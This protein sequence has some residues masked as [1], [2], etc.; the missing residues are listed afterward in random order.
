MTAREQLHEMLDHLAWANRRVWS[1]VQKSS[2][3]PSERLVAHLLAAE[4]VW[5]DRIESGT[6]AEPVWPDGLPTDGAA[7][8]E[9]SVRRI[10]GVLERETDLDRAVHYTNTRGQPF[11]TPVRHILVHL[12]L[13][14]VYHR[15][16]IAQ[17]LRSTGD[18]PEDTDFIQFVREN[19]G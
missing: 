6:S 19:N 7:A 13:H 11:I 16:Q 17:A 3:A 2:S 8:I 4:R 10:R 15:G 5:L 18:V 12:M 1:V 14:G 9:D